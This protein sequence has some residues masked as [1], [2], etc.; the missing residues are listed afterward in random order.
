[1]PTPSN[2]LNISSAGLVKFDGTS[3]FSGVTVTNHNML[4]G[5]SSNG[6]TSVAP[7]A[8][9][10]VPVISQGASADPAFGTAV[11]AGGGTGSTS[12]TTYGPVV[13]AATSTG[14]LTSVAPSST[15]GVPL[16]SQ[17]SSANPAFGTAV[18]AGGGTGRT[19]LTNHGVLVGA[20]TSAITQLAAGSAG[21]VLQSGGASADPSYS[22]P[23][24]PSASG[25][26]RKILVSDGTNNV[27]STETWATPGA[28]GNVLTSDGTNWTSAAAPGGGL[29]TV[30]IT[31]TNA[32]IK[33]LD[34]TPI[35]ILAAQGS[36]V[37]TIPVSVSYKLIYGGSN[38]FVASGS[39]DIC[40]GTTAI[41]N[42]IISQTDGSFWQSTANRYIV[43]L[44]SSFGGAGGAA[45]ATVENAAISISRTSAITGNAANNNTAKVTMLYYTIS[46]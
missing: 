18:V 46:I 7:S 24:Y 43:N 11:V 26:S 41:T 25:T 9:S 29:S 5:A 34:T 35:T 40:Y 8:T 4:V 15:S 1:M 6:I 22:T 39:T 45:P 31:L 12:F 13:A 33:A 38:A 21:Q 2:S 3:A 16:I 32:Q 23:T 27:Y 19:S 17:G 37:V 10:G 44:N 36:G 42:V 28:S 30:T 14:A 20:S